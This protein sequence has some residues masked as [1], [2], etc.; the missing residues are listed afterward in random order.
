MNDRMFFVQLKFNPY[1]EGTLLFSVLKNTRTPTRS[2]ATE[3]QVTT[4]ETHTTF[5]RA[6]DHG[7]PGEREQTAKDFQG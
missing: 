2:I 7:Q 4:H 1:E 6:R 3:R 5:A